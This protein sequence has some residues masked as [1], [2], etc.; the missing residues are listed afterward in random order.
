MYTSVKVDIDL[1]FAAFQSGQPI[2]IAFYQLKI[3]TEFIYATSSNKRLLLSTLFLI[4]FLV[5]A[6]YSK[7]LLNIG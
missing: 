4:N 2:I 7:S 3:Y 5:F 6:F 1:F